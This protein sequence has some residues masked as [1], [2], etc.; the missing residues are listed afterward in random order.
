[1][2]ILNTQTVKNVSHVVDVSTYVLVMRVILEGCSIRLP[3]GN[4]SKTIAGDWNLSGLSDH[5]RYGY[6]KPLIVFAEVEPLRNVKI[7]WDII[8]L[9]S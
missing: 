1:M 3:G 4:L 7:Y 2:K 9:P 5:F 6:C 8:T